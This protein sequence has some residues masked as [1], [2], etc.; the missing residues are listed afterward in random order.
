MTASTDARFVRG[1]KFLAAGAAIALMATACGGGSETPEASGSSDAALKIGSLLPTT[2][3]LAFLGPPEIAGVDLAIQEINDAGGVNGKDV[4]VIHRDSGDTTTNIA[5][6]STTD[7][8]GQGVSAVIGAASS[9]VSKTVINQIT[10]AGVIQFSPANTSPDFTDWDD[11]GLFWRTAPSDVM[12]GKILGNFMVSQGAQNIGMI[13][14]NDAYGTGLATNIKGAVEEAGGTVVAEPMFNEGDS[15]F[16]AQVDEVVAAKPDAIAIISFDQSKQI[17]PLLVQKGITPDQMYFV[18]GN[19]SD[20]S[21]DFDPGT[22]EGA[23]GTQ[24]GSFAKDDFKERLAEIDDS[25]EVW[26]YAGESYDATNLVALAAVA[27]GSTDGKAI[28]AKLEEVSK[29][30]EKCTDFASC[31][32][33]LDA[34][35]DIDY[36]GISGPISFSEKGD[37]SEG[38]MG[39]YKYDGDNIPQPEMEE[40]GA[41]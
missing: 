12:Q 26:N 13:V 15:Q 18:D 17:V 19:L 32:T 14:L 29:D 2:G 8:L 25:L 11:D 27:A 38:I 33:L 23:Y 22:L 10:G 21:K 20:Y 37:V 24:P 30:G 40:A 28:A 9:G 35:T 5:T 16:S 4:E 1:A 31:K 36:D 39:I 3:A 7:M 41:V 6:Q 34:G